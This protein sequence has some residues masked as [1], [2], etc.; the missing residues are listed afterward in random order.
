MALNSFWD[1]GASRI[2]SVYDN[3]LNLS[4]TSDENKQVRDNFMK[5]AQKQ[6]TKLSSMDV[7][8]PNVQ[9]QGLGVFKPLLEDQDIIQDDFLTKRQQSIFADAEKYKHDEKTKGAGYHIDNLTDALIPFDGF[10]AGT[11]RGE[12]GQVFQK[13]KNASYTPYYDVSKERMDILNHCKANKINNTTSGGQY[14]RTHSD[15]S[16]YQEQLY[17]CLDA[18]ASDA[19]RQQIGISA[20]ARYYKHNDA[21]RNDYVAAADERIDYLTREK[22]LAKARQLAFSKTK[23]N[24]EQAKHEGDAVKKYEDEIKKSKENKDGILGWNDDYI[25]KNFNELAYTSLY[26]ESNKHFAAGFAHLDIEDK[27]KEDSTWITKYVQ[28]NLNTR[29]HETFA[30]ENAQNYQAFLYKEQLQKEDNAAK[31]EIERK[32]GTIGGGNSLEDYLGKNADGTSIVPL[33]AEEEIGGNGLKQMNEDIAKLDG[34]EK[35]GRANLLEKIQNNPELKQFVTIRNGMTVDNMTESEYGEIWRKINEY[36]ITAQKDGK[37]NPLAKELGELHQ[38]MLN[39][40]NLKANKQQLLNEMIDKTKSEHPGLFENFNKGVDNLINHYEPITLRNGEI[41]DKNRMKN[42]LLGKDPSYSSN[43]FVTRGGTSYGAIVNKSNGNQEG[44]TNI[45]EKFYHLNNDKNTNFNEHLNANISKDI[46]KQRYG[47]TTGN[48]LS[49]GPGYNYIASIMGGLG[50]IS[51]PGEE[52]AIHFTTN[53]AP[54][55]DPTTGWTGVKAFDKKGNPI[56]ATQMMNA[57]NEN[58]IGHSVY[59]LVPGRNDVIMVQ[60][61][62]FAQVKPKLYEQT[63][64]ENMDGVE[65]NVKNGGKIPAIGIKHIIGT[66]P[67]SKVYGIKSIMSMVPGQGVKH[68]I[69]IHDPHNKKNPDQDIEIPA[70]PGVDP[71]E[72]IINSLNLVLEGLLNKTVEEILNGQ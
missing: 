15:N 2:K 1:Q 67:D 61:P 41:I 14:L 52:N 31:F 23:G 9:R 33:K 20:R 48:L 30:H 39:N 16:L 7:S 49:T 70:K 71:K 44:I 5:E 8:D 53:G 37:N 11:K 63:I 13:A 68:L 12:I 22:D 28:A 26:R 35:T 40:G 43:A 36:R 25:N 55:V 54:S 10:N 47:L 57:M 34:N 24:E 45:A 56:S 59:K 64:R 50:E 29:L 62:A 66:A 3:A 17:G 19:F 69:T 51:K 65:L 42:I 27:L 46:L 32:K 58:G 38:S 18:G 6:I 21:L 72:Q 4:L 60:I